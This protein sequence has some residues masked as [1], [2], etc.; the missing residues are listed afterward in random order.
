MTA[1][2]ATI[3]RVPLAMSSVGYAYSSRKFMPGA[4][5]IMHARRCTMTVNI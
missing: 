3:E 5:D 2:P 4:D 1:F